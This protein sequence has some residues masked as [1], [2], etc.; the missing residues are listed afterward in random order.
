M[1]G[2][3]Q[4]VWF[5]R[6][7][8]VRDHGPLTRAAQSGLVVP[9][10]IIEPEIINSSDFD[11][12]HWQFIRESLIDLQISLK[13]LGGPLQVLKGNAVE[14]LESMHKAFQFSTLWAHEE[15]GNAITY[16]R[17]L[18]VAKWADAK[19]ISFMELPQNGVVRRL[20]NRD[21]WARQ[22]ERRMQVQK[23]DIPTNISCPG[24]LADCSIPSVSD[25]Q[26]E[27]FPRE[28]DIKGGESAG[29]E[30]LSSFIESR[31]HRYHREMSS[32]NT[33][34]ESCSFEQIRKRTGLSESDVIKIMR[35]E[36][37]LKSFRHWRSRVNGRITKHRK[38]LRSTEE[39][40]MDSI[41]AK[42]RNSLIE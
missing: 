26:L 32:P 15:T 23:L 5:K 31:G 10:Y 9:I 19:N 27:K 22:W 37:K 11:A 21:G 30:M 6:D 16:R 25:L 7:L 12:L 17:D 40:E 18:A 39:I 34:Y 1:D 20:Q 36:L 28:T 13:M 8:R 42:T 35:H 2:S 33:T 4:C 24:R 38:R 3:V 41:A 29:R 14:V